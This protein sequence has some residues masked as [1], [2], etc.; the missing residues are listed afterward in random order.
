MNEPFSEIVPIEDR[1]QVSLYLASSQYDLRNQLVTIDSN[2]SR[3]YLK[4]NKK[5]RIHRSFSCIIDYVP[6]TKVDAV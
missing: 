2:I 5:E 6:T 4:T 1:K 3:N